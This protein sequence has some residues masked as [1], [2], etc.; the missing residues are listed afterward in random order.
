[1]IKE[2]MYQCKSPTFRLYGATPLGDQTCPQE[3]ALTLCTKCISAVFSKLSL[4]K[5]VN[6]ECFYAIFKLKI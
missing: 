2:C 6:L 4:V 1:M 3:D 5:C